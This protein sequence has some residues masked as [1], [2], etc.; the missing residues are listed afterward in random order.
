[1]KF[2]PGTEDR[3]ILALLTEELN[4]ETSTFVMAFDTEGATLLAQQQVPTRF[5]F[6]GVEFI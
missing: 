3:I 1:M 2:I 6:E 5:K 4:G